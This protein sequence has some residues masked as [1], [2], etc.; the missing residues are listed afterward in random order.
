MTL[1]DLVRSEARDESRTLLVAASLAG[2][3]NALIMALVNSAASAQGD[4]TR[5][6]IMIGLAV[7]LY[8]VCV[9]K[10]FH[11]TTEIIEAAL[12]KIKLRVIDKIEQAELQQLEGIGTSVIYDRLT[13]NISVI[14]ESA[15][16]IANVLQSLCIVLFASFYILSISLPGFVLLVLLNVVGIMMWSTKNAEIGGQLDAEAKER[17]TFLDQLTDLLKGFKESRFSRKRSRDI[18]VDVA[19]TAEDLRT[20]TVKA[21]NLFNDNLILAQCVLFAMLIGVVFVLPQHVSIETSSL[22]TL[23]GGVLFFWGPLGG[24]VSGIPM[25][26]RSNAALANI[27]S[28]EEKIDETARNH[29]PAGR[30]EDPWTGSF[31][32]I[33]VRDVSFAYPPDVGGQTFHIGPLNLSIT[34][35]EVVFIVGAN[36]SGKST[37][38]KVLTGLYPATGG[39]VCIDGKTLCP[40]NVAAYREMFAAIFSDFHLFSRLYGLLDVDEKSVLDLLKQMQ[41]A[42]KTSFAKGGFTKRDLSTGQRKRLAMIVALLEDRP[43]CLFDE[44]AADQDP[45]FRSYFYD[46]LIPSLKRRGKTVI[47]VSHDDRYF[48][49]ADRVVTLEYG[50]VRSID[51]MDRQV[52]N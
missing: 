20:A 25:Y 16:T 49:C 32:T 9:R 38:M 37:F 30:T 22:T 18:R 15:G 43:I 41:I 5:Q 8:V 48:H 45:E 42:D 26:M 3:A 23:V 10:T 33:E 36:G 39:E 24:V 44:W 2:A 40:E 51:S 4:K 12:Q 52:T 27:Q 13:E 47:A 14:S 17:V 31:S 21:N 6:F 1:T 29:V 35:G 34:Q 46:E 19:Q 28:L 7:V 11:R 50:K